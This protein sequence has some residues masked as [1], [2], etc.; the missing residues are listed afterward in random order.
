MTSTTIEGGT[1]RPQ[2]PTRVD[3]EA[4]FSAMCEAWNAQ[5]AVGTAAMYAADGRLIDPFG[6]EHDRR[7][8]IE[9][10]FEE[11]FRTLL[12]GSTTRLEVESVR[13]LVP[14]LAVVDAKQTFTGGLPDMHATLIVRGGQERA[15]VVE[16]RPYA[17]LELPP[18]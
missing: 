3:V 14:G 5:D 13:E 6:R 15:E 12:A 9:E 4:L 16:C 11:N 8:R 2:T 10:A 18:A 17:V 1:K 7:D